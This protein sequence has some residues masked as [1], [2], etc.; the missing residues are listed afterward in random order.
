M[1]IPQ[2]WYFQDII[3]CN[4]SVLSG[5]YVPTVLKSKDKGKYYFRIMIFFFSYK[6]WLPNTVVK[7]CS[8]KKWNIRRIT[9]IKQVAHHKT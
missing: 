8:A 3:C 5:V 6:Y 1:M 7:S 9:E 2:S 4:D